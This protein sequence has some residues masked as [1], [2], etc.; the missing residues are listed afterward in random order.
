MNTLRSHLDS[1]PFL[2]SAHLNW[3]IVAQTAFQERHA[4]LPMLMKLVQHVSAARPHADGTI[5]TFRV[6]SNIIKI[7]GDVYV[8]AVLAS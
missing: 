5:T 6:Y 1:R 2:A 7:V 3:M 4:S 8:P